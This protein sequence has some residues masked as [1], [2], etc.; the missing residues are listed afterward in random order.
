MWVRDIFKKREERGEFN[1][2]IKEL[3]LHDQEYFFRSFRMKP[4]TFALLL[5]GLLL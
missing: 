2:L 5:H 4:A 3:K 1:I